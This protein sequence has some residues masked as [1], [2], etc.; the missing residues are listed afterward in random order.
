ML[1]AGEEHGSKAEARPG[2]WEHLRLNGDQDSRES[3]QKQ[4]Q[5]VGDEEAPL[6]E[7]CTLL[8]SGAQVTQ[9]FLLSCF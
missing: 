9:H 4:V 8:L 6:G 5:R 7:E 1:R 2:H 3:K